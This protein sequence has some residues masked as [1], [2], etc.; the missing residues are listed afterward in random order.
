MSVAAEVIRVLRSSGRALT[1]AEI[2]DAGNFE[3]KASLMAVLSDMAGSH[4]T[5]TKQDAEPY[6]YT[7]RD[8]AHVDGIKERSGPQKP[9][10]E[11]SRAAPA[12][13]APIVAIRDIPT[14][15]E[16]HE[17][18]RAAATAVKPAAPAPARVQ[19]PGSGHAEAAA[20]ARKLYDDTLTELIGSAETCGDPVLKMLAMRTKAAKQIVDYFV[21]GR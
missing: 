10:A 9:V 14:L 18:Q 5:R 20:L 12:P 8:G 16:A 21:E 3:A 1:G 6:R 19:Q 17:A 11:T 15:R 13:R 2:Y 7:I 4:L